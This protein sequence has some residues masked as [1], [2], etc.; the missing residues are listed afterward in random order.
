MYSHMQLPKPKVKI[1]LLESKSQATKTSIAQEIIS[2]NQTLSN[3]GF[4]SI[5]AQI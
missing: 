2:E 5:C 1:P 4:K 3:P